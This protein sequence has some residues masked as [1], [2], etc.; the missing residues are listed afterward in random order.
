MGN[1]ANGG[2]QDTVSDF[3]V[4]KGTNNGDVITLGGGVTTVHGG[5]GDD[6][7]HASD[8]GGETIYGGAGNDTMFAGSGADTF[9]WKAEDLGNF[10]DTVNGFKVGVDTLLLDS[11]LESLIQGTLT[12][13]GD[14]PGVSQTESVYTDALGNSLGIECDA[15]SCTLTLGTGSGNQT[16]QLNNIDFGTYTSD[17]DL[18]QLIAAIIKVDTG[19]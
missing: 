12:A 11:S 5:T 13:L 17:D 19:N 8:V 10:T 16:I 4:F 3:E 6:V 2:W 14:N 18:A 15:D 7:I 9:A 1:P